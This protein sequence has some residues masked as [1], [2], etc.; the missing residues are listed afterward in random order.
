MG[1]VLN[2]FLISFVAP[3]HGH[4]GYSFPSAGK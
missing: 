2:L 3:V 1:K 4:A